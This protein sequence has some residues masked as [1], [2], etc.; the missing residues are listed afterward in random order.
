[1]N[2]SLKD[3]RGPVNRTVVYAPEDTPILLG[4]VLE[5][6]LRSYLQALVNS[7]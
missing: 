5:G 2:C 6:V 7:K 4:K 1:M 3:A